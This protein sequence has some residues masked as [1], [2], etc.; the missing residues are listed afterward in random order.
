M[1]TALYRAGE[2]IKSL[3]MTVRI[4]MLKPILANLILEPSLRGAPNFRA[5]WQPKTVKKLHFLERMDGHV[6]SR[7]SLLAMTARALSPFA[8]V[9]V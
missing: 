1:R 5:T 4:K 6:G 8:K 2:E 9:A 7:K 3:H